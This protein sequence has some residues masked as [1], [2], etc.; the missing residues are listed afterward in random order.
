MRV[1]P[2]DLPEG[3][4]YRSFHSLTFREIVDIGRWLGLPFPDHVA[5]HGLAVSD[6]TTFGATFS[7]EVAEV[8]EEWAKRIV[9]DE[10]DLERAR[11]L[12][13]QTDQSEAAAGRH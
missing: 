9:E 7:P 3:F 4:G 1:V 8:W 2:D 6:T 5:I 12:L 10:F 13:P 11:T